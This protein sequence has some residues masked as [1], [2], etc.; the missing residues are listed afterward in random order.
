MLT[1]P[2]LISLIRLA[3]IPVFVWLLI[4]KD[5]P[6]AAGWLLGLI[7]ATDWVDGYLA[8]K[9]D[10]VSEVGKILDPLADRIAVAAAVIGG[11]ISGYLPQWFAWALIVRETLVAIG[12]LVIALRGHTSLEVRPMGKLATLLLYAAVAW[13]F[14][15]TE[16]EVMHWAAWIVGIP[17]LILY[18]VVGVQYAA[19]GLRAIRRHDEGRAAEL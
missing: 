12:A 7:G 4:G 1:I 16:W 6:F 3:L 5:D 19:D 17:G 2:N 9:L 13:F 11:L 8:R 10:Q 18:Y 15:G 14:V